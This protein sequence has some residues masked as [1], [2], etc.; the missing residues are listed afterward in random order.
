MNM[1][2]NLLISNTSN[3]GIQFYTEKPKSYDPLQVKVLPQENLILKDNMKCFV[4][5]CY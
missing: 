3:T 2:N 1:E 5:N 4:L